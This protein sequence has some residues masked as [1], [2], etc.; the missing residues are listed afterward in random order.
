MYII[1]FLQFMT[2]SHILWPKHLNAPQIWPHLPK[3]DTLRVSFEHY[4][5]FGFTIIALVKNRYL[6]SSDGLRA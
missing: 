4:Q 3:Y 5:Q 2:E 6:S 1:F